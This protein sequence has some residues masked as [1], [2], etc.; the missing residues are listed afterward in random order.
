[1]AEIRELSST[2]SDQIAAGE[3][4]ERPSSVVKELLENAIDAGSTQIKIKFL[5]AGLKEIVIEDNG[6]GI[7][8]DQIELAFRR[9]ATSKIATTADLFKIQTLGFRGEALASISAVAQV[10]II[11]NTGD[12]DGIVARFADGELQDKEP[13][14]AK[15]GTKIIVQNLFYN[16]PA[17]LKY[18]KSEKTEITKIIDIV[19]RIALSYPDLAI[20]LFNGS[21]ELLATFGNGN[22]QQDLA[23]IYGRSIAQ[24][25]LPFKNEDADFQI[26]GYITAP[27]VTRANRN[28]ISI[29]LNGRYIKNYQLSRAILEG[30]GSLLQPGRFPIAVIA[31]KMDPLLVDVNV[32]PTKQEVRLSKEVTLSRLIN[33]TIYQTLSDNQTATSGSAKLANPTDET[34]FDNLVFN[35]TKQNPAEIGEDVQSEIVTT[36]STIEQEISIDDQ[37]PDHSLISSTWQKNVG[38]QKLLSAFGTKTGRRFIG[39]NSNDATPDL[40]TKSEQISEAGFPELT[41]KAQLASG[42]LV[43]DSEESFYL[44][45]PVAA[46]ARISYEALFQNFQELGQDQQALLTPLIFDLNQVE[47]IKLSDHLADFAK[48]G[49]NFSDF[50]Q[51][52]LVLDT[53]PTWLPEGQEEK[54]IQKIFDLYLASTHLEFSDFKNKVLLLL[55]KN[56]GQKQHQ[57]YNVQTGQDLVE[58]L[59]QCQNPYQSPKGQPVIV[60]F[61]QRDLDKMFKKIQRGDFTV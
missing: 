26:E 47:F 43:Y 59:A 36:S 18:L 61:S 12:I 57:T 51:T 39:E 42:Y 20:S 37:D 49:L 31:I 33:Q 40:Q 46:V 3:V 14:A 48:I 34:D 28:Y 58:Q 24:N 9:H 30:Y 55:S 11:T 7:A 22:L 35:L 41:F 6:S 44:L 19:N 4:I 53:H 10:E 60:R 38:V 15:R 45:D 25:M 50:G 29:L 52:S 1:M 56:Q 13:I 17:R 8:A 54:T 27:D 32:H 23:Q 2:I 16:T 21:K 5:Q